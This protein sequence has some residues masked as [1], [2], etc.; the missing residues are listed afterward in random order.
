MSIYNFQYNIEED[1]AIPV[2][3]EEIKKNPFFLLNQCPIVNVGNKTPTFQWIVLL[4]PN[5]LEIINSI[6]S[7]MY[8]DERCSSLIFSVQHEMPISWNGF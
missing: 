2:K 5:S 6:S 8:Y 3:E 7:S 1:R 4:L